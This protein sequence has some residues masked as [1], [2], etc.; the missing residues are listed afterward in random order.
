MTRNCHKGQRNSVFYHIPVLTHFPDMPSCLPTITRLPLVRGL[1][2]LTPSRDP[3]CSIC[4]F[5]MPTCRSVALEH[6]SNIP[7]PPICTLNDD[8]LL[9][10]FHLYQLDIRDEDNDDGLLSRN[11]GRE[12]WWY[13]LAQVSGRWRRLILAS[14]LQLDL[15][16]V[17]TYGVPVEAMLEH[18]PFL[19]LIIF[20]EDEGREMTPED[21]KGVLLA[22]SLSHR[23][24]VR[25]IA[26]SMPAPRLGTLTVAMGKQFSNLELLHI[27]SRTVGETTLVLPMAFQAPKLSRLDLRYI[28]LPVPSTLF[29]FPPGLALLWLGGIPASCYFSSSYILNCLSLMPQL[30]VLGLEFHSVIPTTLSDA[31][32]VRLPNLRVLIFTGVSAYL[33]NVL[34]HI[35]APILNVLHISFLVQ[36]TFTGSLLQCMQSSRELVFNSLGL[37]FYRDFVE[38]RADPHR[39]L[40][41]QPLYLRINHTELNLQVESAVEI[42]DTLTPVLSGVDKLTLSPVEHDLS[43]ES[44]IHVCRAQWRRLLTPFRNVKVL[45]LE[46]ELVGELSRSLRLQSGETPLEILPNLEELSYSGTDVAD[47]FTHFVR[48][49]QTAGYP[50]RLISP[51]ATQ[52]RPVIDI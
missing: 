8:I 41:E 39:T 7:N 9:H 38:L 25:R 44:D 33:E 47:A 12:R 23:V 17:C 31:R 35:D 29:T 36:P 20:Y 4:F 13:K 24:R 10:V 49:R 37:A 3:Q 1:R 50:V 28:A 18:S 15:H 2:R 52:E 51:G 16:L 27:A 46:N 45:R 19:P 43:T 14:A 34:L 42:L 32:H 26:L 6:T 21:E 30:E 11:W 22:L 40:W 5:H 48:E